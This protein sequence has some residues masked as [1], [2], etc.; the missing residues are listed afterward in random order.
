[1]KHDERLPEEL[2]DPKNWPE[3]MRREFGDD[4]GLAAARRHRRT[5]NGGANLMALVLGGCHFKDEA[6]Q[7]RQVDQLATAAD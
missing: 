2:K 1:M 7:R 6:L 5:L 3:D 4:Q